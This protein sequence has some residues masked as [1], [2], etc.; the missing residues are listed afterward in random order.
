MTLEDRCLG[1]SSLPRVSIEPRGNSLQD[2][3]KNWGPVG[4]PREAQKLGQP[5][6]QRHTCTLGRGSFVSWMDG[7]GSHC[8]NLEKKGGGKYLLLS[9]KQEAVGEICLLMMLLRQPLLVIPD[10]YSA[11]LC[12]LKER[13]KGTT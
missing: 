12:F 8:S 7:V 1:A 2:Q 10:Q 3:S 5:P 9:E 4:F 13:H 6:S 11:H